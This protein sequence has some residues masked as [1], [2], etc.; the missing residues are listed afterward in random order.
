MTKKASNFTWHDKVSSC[1]ASPCFYDTDDG[2]G[3][4]GIGITSLTG[5]ELVITF[6]EIVT[7]AGF[8][9][10][11]EAN[12]PE[13]LSEME[14]VKALND[15]DLTR[16]NIDWAAARKEAYNDKELAF[17]FARNASSDIAGALD[18]AAWALG[19]LR[20]VISRVNESDRSA[21][22]VQTL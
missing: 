21:E 16:E 9:K 6:I 2:L 20:H 1:G 19:V 12:K 18:S 17:Y 4:P 11:F 7:S 13:I 8:I 14:E 5:E 3:N 15:Y 10:W 22:K